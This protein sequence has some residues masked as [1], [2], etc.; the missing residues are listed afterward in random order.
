VGPRS[1]ESD[2]GFVRSKVPARPVVPLPADPPD[3]FLT[4]PGKGASREEAS[5][6]MD[7]T[8]ASMDRN[9]NAFWEFVYDREAG[10]GV[11]RLIPADY[12]TLR[13]A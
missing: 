3:D 11:T 8:A 13:P 12:V 6:F 5:R 9:G 4:L 1:V 10:T 2:G 7:A